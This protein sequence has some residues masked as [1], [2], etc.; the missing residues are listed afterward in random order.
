VSFGCFE[1]RTPPLLELIKP[2]DQSQ[3]ATDP[4]TAHGVTD[5]MSMLA[6]RFNQEIFIKDA[7]IMDVGPVYRR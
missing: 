6:H 7:Q 3:R 2:S 1:Q 5:P 4:A